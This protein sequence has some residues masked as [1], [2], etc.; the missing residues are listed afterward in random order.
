MLNQNRPTIGYLLENVPDGYEFI[1]WTG[2]VSAARELNANL[3]CFAGGRLSADPKTPNLQ[4]VLFDLVNE[5]NVDGL[6][7]SSS[8]IGNDIDY[9][10]LRK[11]INRFSPIPM[12]SIGTP[13]KGI[14]S[15]SVENAQ[16][17]NDLVTHMIDEHG[18]KKIA[19]IKGPVSNIEA[20]IRYEAYLSALKEAGI[21]P[22]PRLVVEGDYLRDSGRYAIVELLDKRRADFDALIAANDFM[23]LYA[24]K[25]LQKRGISVPEDVAIGG[26]DNVDEGVFDIPSI[27]T[28]HQPLYEVGFQ[29]VVTLLH[30]LNGKKVPELITLPTR[31]T[32]RNSCG[33]YKP[34]SIQID[35]GDYSSDTSTTQDDTEA[36]NQVIADC[37]QSLLKE[38]QIINQTINNPQWLNDLVNTLWEGIVFTD[39]KAIVS[40]LS[41]IIPETIQNGVEISIWQQIL[42]FIFEAIRSRKQSETTNTIIFNLQ[43]E[44]LIFLGS[45]GEHFQKHVRISEKEHYVLLSRL[46]E[47]NTGVLN[48]DK[49][50]ELLEQ[51]L[52]SV[53]IESCFIALFTDRE[54]SQKAKLFLYF[55]PDNLSIDTNT[56][57]P[58]NQLIPGGIV[59]LKDRF[60]FLTLPLVSNNELMGFILF[61]IGVFSGSFYGIL[62][63]QIAQI[64]KKEEMVDQ[65]KK[66]SQVLEKTVE[67]RTSDL[68]D[69]VKQLNESM[70]R[71]KQLAIE[72]NAAND[73]KSNFLANM[74]H[75]IRTPMN[76]ILGMV[77]L[78]LETKL[79][80]EQSEMAKT[81]QNSADDLL[82][83]IDDILDF[84][85]IEAG[86]LE[87]EIID[88]DLRSSIETISDLLALKAVNKGL[89]FV[90]LVNS[91]VPVLLK[92]DPGRL[93][94]ILINLA[95]NAIKFTETGEVVI[96][97]IL[98]NEEDN[99][100]TIRFEVSDTGIGISEEG[101]KQLFKS[102]SQVD[103]S[104]TRRYGGT[105]LGLVI[106]KQLVYLMNGEIGVDS[107]PGEGSTFWFTA[108]FEKQAKPVLDE[109]AHS[110]QLKGKR[111]IVV[112]DI[113]ANR[114]VFQEYLKSWGCEID[115]A[116]SGEKA[117]VKLEEAAKAQNPFEI[118][119]LDMTMPMM[120]GAT[121]GKKIKENELTNQTILIMLTSAGIRGEATRVS[122]IGFAAY[123]TKPIKKNQLLN[124]L[125]L[126]LKNAAVE[127]KKQSQKSLITQYTINESEKKV[128]I[129]L[130]EDNK[131]NQKL[132]I[133]VLEKMEF[134]V[135]VAENGREAIE[136]LK[137]K[138]YDVV[139]MDLQ[140]PELG[141]LEATKLIRDSSSKVIN[142]N[143]PIIAM[144]AHVMYDDKVKCLEAGMNGFI[145]K[146]F[147]KDLL[148]EEIQKVLS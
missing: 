54:T 109:P 23:A 53:N 94:Q 46:N 35:Q 26:F 62:A 115:Q 98:E 73:A 82:V 45:L 9:E 6:I 104:V 56:E 51:E 116:E 131:V 112:D 36:F 16:G 61:D 71:T 99:H 80:E 137:R 17:M 114:R 68:V 139:L 67:E 101:K 1:C 60:Q 96:K 65:L 8:P 132:A 127:A 2:I 55:S 88:F 70:K 52:S 147:K 48:T 102:F 44:V 133:K 148:F 11:F 90:S 126:A 39:Y 135:D 58:A 84:S 89:E 40:K 106:S 128:H 81:V 134:R 121:L 124:C 129:L 41:K 59:D 63:S 66:H 30:I 145:S 20:N 91:N 97:V 85:K 141:G 50:Q 14:T 79:D 34:F 7:I 49:L 43:K 64:L 3:L 77:N 103:A 122:D 21:E 144:T 113:K 13:F 143:V 87:F 22:D 28:V 25:E 125:L 130:T 72:A 76:G 119:L 108:K 33:C 146:P 10:S 100:V 24:M 15:L 105:G 95:G 140:M 27:T 4:N 120:D 110:H 78:L 111:I 38:I 107:T 93:K 117:L 47:F 42:S 92:G 31:L 123:L 19:F 32:I 5:N 138:N 142:Q 86:K 18:L 136:A 75:E 12:V 69:T 37:E 29:S 118:A 74:S 83:I 57:Y